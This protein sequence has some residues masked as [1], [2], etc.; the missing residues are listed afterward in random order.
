MMPFIFF[1]SIF[2]LSFNMHYFSLK[3]L[4]LNVIMI[5]IASRMLFVVISF[6]ASANVNIGWCLTII[7]TAEV[8]LVIFN[9]LCFVEESREEKTLFETQNFEVLS[10]GKSFQAF[11]HNVILSSKTINWCCKSV[12]IRWTWV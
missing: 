12:S 3:A 4:A 6:C 9:I 7:G 11:K 2:F 1:V 5:L 8:N 10:T